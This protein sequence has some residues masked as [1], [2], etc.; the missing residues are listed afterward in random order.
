V[1][2]SGDATA[3][4]NVTVTL[5]WAQRPWFFEALAAAVI[6]AI[7][8]AFAL[9]DVSNSLRRARWTHAVRTRRSRVRT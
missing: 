4:T 1:V 5:T 6:G 8:A 9:I 7:I 2:T 3:L